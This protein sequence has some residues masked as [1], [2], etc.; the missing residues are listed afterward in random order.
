MYHHRSISDYP[1]AADFLTSIGVVVE[2]Q[3]QHIHAGRNPCWKGRASDGE[4]VFVKIEELIDPKASVDG[5]RS[6]A[7]TFFDMRVDSAELKNFVSAIDPRAISPDGRI[8]VYPWQSS[9]SGSDLLTEGKLDRAVVQGVAASIQRLHAAGTEARDIAGPH[10]AESLPGTYGIP[11]LP[12]EL[13]PTLSG[14]QLCAWALMHND[15]QLMET[16][17]ATVLAEYRASDQ[18]Y[19]HG[20]LRI[21][22]VLLDEAD[23]NRFSAIIDWES[24][25]RG[26]PA[27][28]T[29]TFMGNVLNIIATT[30]V[31]NVKR[32]VAEPDWQEQIR[33]AVE[34]ARPY[35]IDFLSAYFGKQRVPISEMR[36]HIVRAI[37]FAGWHQFDRL[38]ASADSAALISPLTKAMAGVGRTFLLFPHDIDEELG[39][40]H[41]CA[42]F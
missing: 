12:V 37:R 36:D 22:Q 16:A 10:I 35:L 27:R 7:L 2:D 15:K 34:C 20:D 28:D 6:R 38:L 5:N 23:G 4:L 40:T 1:D 24:F 33:R 17:R 39:L 14:G 3:D 8:Q 41:A 30:E 11:A 25:G 32:T 42:S 19:I 9:V 13:I 31:W 26:D 21:D 18:T 29:G